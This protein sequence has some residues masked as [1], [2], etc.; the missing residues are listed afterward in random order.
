M[1]AVQSPAAAGHLPTTTTAAT[2]MFA[3]LGRTWSRRHG[4][5]SSGY[6]TNESICR[7]VLS[8]NMQWRGGSRKNRR[9]DGRPFFST[10]APAVAARFSIVPVAKRALKYYDGLLTSHRLATTTLSGMILA[11]ASDAVTQTAQ[12]CYDKKNRG[13]DESEFDADRA[14]AFACFGG[15][16]TGPITYVWLSFIDRIATLHFGK[17]RTLGKVVLQMSVY[18]PIIYLPL[19][20]GVNASV[21]GWSMSEL[22]RRFSDE[23]ASSLLTLWT[24]WTPVFWFAF[25]K[26]PVRQQSVFFSAVS[27]AWNALLSYISNPTTFEEGRSG[28]GACAPAALSA[29]A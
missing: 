1:E 23:Y 14:L 28:L 6:C 18:E 15:A 10:T 20:F 11:L 4:S 21:R 7:R 13:E 22:K 9:G 8:R 26:L 17:F 16:I 29:R 12:V 3:S 19:F 25:R 27:F 24:F 5:R 2:S